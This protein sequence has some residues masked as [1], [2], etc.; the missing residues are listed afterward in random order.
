MSEYSNKAHVVHHTSPYVDDAQFKQN[1]D[2]RTRKLE[3][4][5]L[6]LTHAG[7]GIRFLA[8]VIDLILIHCI[9]SII[10]APIVKIGG[11]E[12]VYL[13]IKLFSVE[14][15]LSAIIFFSYFVILTYCFRATLGKMIL[16]LK[17][18]STKEDKLS[19]ETVLTRELFGRYIS[20]SFFSL[21]Y[22][23]VLFNPKKRGIHDLLSDTYVVKED[24]EHI[25]QFILNEGVRDLSV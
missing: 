15:I 1:R 19:V 13:G 8:Y 18:L 9:N 23:V 24:K 25:R 6:E 21:L 17:V 10:T 3:D 16:G 2:M 11:L 20:K 22:L 14:H 12:D 7:F 5:I 4:D